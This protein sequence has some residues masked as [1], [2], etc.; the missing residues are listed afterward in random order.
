VPHNFS[1]LAHICGKN[2][3]TQAQSIAID[4][5]KKATNMSATCKL[6]AGVTCTLHF[7][8][9]G[10]DGSFAVVLPNGRNVELRSKKGA[11]EFVHTVGTYFISTNLT[12]TDDK[13]LTFV[14]ST[15]LTVAQAASPE[16]IASGI[17]E[18]ELR[19]FI[20]HTRDTLDALSTDRNW[21]RSGTVLRH[22]ELLLRT[23]ALFSMQPSFVKILLSNKGMEAIAKFYSSR[24][25]N[26]TPSHGVAQ[27]ILLLVNNA[28]YSLEPDGLSYEKAFA[29]I[30]KT[31]LLG[32]FIRCACVPVDPEYSLDS[33]KCLQTCLQLVKK[34]L[35]SG[36]RTGDILD[37]VI[38]GKDGP[39]NEKAKSALSRLQSLA[40]LSNSNDSKRCHHCEKN[41]TLGGAKLMKCQR[42]KL[43]YFCNK[44]CQV[45]D[46][47]RHKKTC[48]AISSGILHQWLS[49][50]QITLI[51][52]KKSTRKDRNTIF[53]RRSYS[54]RL[55]F[56]EML[57]RYEMN[58][59]FGLRLV[60]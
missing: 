22:Y 23:V 20:E 38:A 4:T 34:K 6:L 54:W 24:K 49:S 57:L 5:L 59:M 18:P 32:E 44:V 21:L 52:R 8:N 19:T 40:R 50:S 14:Y 30:E 7:S 9:Q 25:K 41:E 45:A 26:D 10:D 16:K 47:K 51:S 11:D 43:P 42:C 1:A 35:K 2:G 17:P 48:T 46:W 60:S 28:L 55:I 37:A 33:L 13:K 58:S 15:M 12:A 56:M 29:I 3:N 36:T 53:P 39:I 27:A 31:G